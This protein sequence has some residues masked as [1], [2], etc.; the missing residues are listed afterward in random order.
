[1][2]T[3]TCDFKQVTADKYTDE[4]LLKALI[5]GLQNSATKQRVLEA[6]DVTFEQAYRTAQTLELS[7][8]N[9]MRFQEKNKINCCSITKECN[10]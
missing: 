10:Q 2:N 9:A 6:D 5:S 8:H 4:M 3:L 7:Q 1:M